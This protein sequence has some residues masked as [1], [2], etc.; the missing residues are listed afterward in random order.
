MMPV[1][2]VQ[3]GHNGGSRKCLVHFRV[4]GLGRR[5]VNLR[6]DVAVKAVIAVPALL[7][8]HGGA[9]VERVSALV[10]ALPATEKNAL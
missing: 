1:L 8:R 2:I 4:D 5:D 6:L 9:Q 10:T 3:P 7:A